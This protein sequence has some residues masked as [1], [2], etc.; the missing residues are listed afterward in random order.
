MLLCLS[1]SPLLA[2][3]IAFRECDV[4]FFGTAKRNGGKRSRNDCNDG[5]DHGE[6]KKAGIN[7][8]A[9]KDLANGIRNAGRRVFRVG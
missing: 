4:F 7:V 9:D 8:V 5:I 3:R 2:L 1:F 6:A